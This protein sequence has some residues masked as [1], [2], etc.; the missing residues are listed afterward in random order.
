MKHAEADALNIIENLLSEIRQITVGASVKETKPGTFYQKSA[1]LLHFH[2]DP[3]GIFAD[4]KIAGKFAR[5]P[6]N[7]SQEQE[8][9][10]LA[11]KSTLDKKTTAI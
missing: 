7:T 10:L 11:L 5:F 2:E 8:E 3:A 6:V 9:F 1:A 4:L